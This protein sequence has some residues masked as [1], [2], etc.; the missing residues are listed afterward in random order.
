MKFLSHLALSAVIFCTTAFTASAGS[1]KDKIYAFAYGTCFNDST[2]YL[3]SVN[4]LSIAS[5]DKKSNLLND[6]SG[7]SD[8]FKA[9]LDKQYKKDHTCTIFFSTS[10]KKLEKKY[11]KLRRKYRKDKESKLV[12][13]P[14]SE[15][16]LD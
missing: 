15:F 8:Q 2:I 1:K 6:R 3:S 10:R 14:V 5:I 11:V 16:C 4:H 12:E 7:Y 9:Y 13:V